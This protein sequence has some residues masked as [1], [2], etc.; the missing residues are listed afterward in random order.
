MQQHQTRSKSKK[1]TGSAKR[2]L[3]QKAEDENDQQESD[4]H[5]V[6]MLLPEISYSQSQASLA[7][8]L[9]HPLGAEIAETARRS[10][11]PAGLGPP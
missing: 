11:I 10:K 1:G 7:K 6:D 2:V 4:Q 5:R 3:G 9:F 8:V